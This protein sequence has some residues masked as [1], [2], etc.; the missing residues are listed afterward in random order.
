MGEKKAKKRETPAKA[1]GLATLIEMPIL[2]TFSNNQSHNKN[3]RIMLK[4]TKQHKATICQQRFI[5]TCGIDV[6]YKYET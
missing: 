3:W 4:Q 5:K 6:Y 1:G 2:P